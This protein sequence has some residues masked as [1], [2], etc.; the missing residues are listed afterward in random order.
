MSHR[1]PARLRWG[2]VSLF[3]N[4]VPA[5][6]STPQEE[7]RT[8]IHRNMSQYLK[9]QSKTSTQG[10]V[11]LIVIIARQHKRAIRSFLL[12]SLQ[13]YSRMIW[14]LRLRLTRPNGC[15]RPF[16]IVIKIEETTIFDWRKKII[17]T[18][19]KMHFYHS[20][21]VIYYEYVYFITSPL[22]LFVVDYQRI[23]GI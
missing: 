12:W 17:Q 23:L 3:R 4:V 8:L 21:F 1:W 10:V 5:S 15:I 7:R 13:W 18:P 14:S 11:H 20:P 6:I 22:F 2:R 19:W 9:V 16:L